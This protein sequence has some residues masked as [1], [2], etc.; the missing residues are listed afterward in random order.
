MRSVPGLALG[1]LAE[2]ERPCGYWCLMGAR[3]SRAETSTRGSKRTPGYALS[4]IERPNSASN[5]GLDLE[6]FAY[7]AELRRS[8]SVTHSLAYKRQYKHKFTANL[9]RA[10]CTL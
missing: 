4:A 2:G 3:K 9:P 8:D 5:S 7:S 10:L 1:L 6:K